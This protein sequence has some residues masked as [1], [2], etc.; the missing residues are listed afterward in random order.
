MTIEQ[1]V[2]VPA[3]RRIFIDLLSELFVGRVK[4]ELKVI[5]EKIEANEKMPVFGCAKGQ[6]RMAADFDAALDDFREYM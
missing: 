2:E 3:S 1:M 6:F 4:L 5:P